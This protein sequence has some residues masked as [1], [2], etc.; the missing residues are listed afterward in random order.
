MGYSKDERTGQGFRAMAST[1]LDESG[2]WNPDA[3]ERALAHGDRDSVGGAYHRGLHWA[4]RVKMMQWSSDYLDAL[5]DGAEILPFKRR[6]S[7]R[8]NRR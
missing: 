3:V 5:R 7:G 1:L 4:E 8:T 6:P 2:K